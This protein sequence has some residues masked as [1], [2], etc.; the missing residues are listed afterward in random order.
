M[1]IGHLAIAGIAKKTWF[2]SENLMLL[3]MA[4][5]GPDLIDKP[6]HLIFG[7]PGRGVSHSLVFFLFISVFSW[8]L[9]PFIGYSVKTMVAGLTMWGT[10]LIGD[11][12]EFDI[13]FWP[14]GA[15]YQ[16]VSKF[17]LIEKLSQFYIDRHYFAQFWMEV[18]C[19]AILALIMVSKMISSRYRKREVAQVA[20]LSCLDGD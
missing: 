2:D 11:F 18:I 13:L 17:N 9:R 12:L 20:E 6:A 10:H 15:P 3:T 16:A 8:L 14:L 1:I 7:F 5:F 19:V 4:S